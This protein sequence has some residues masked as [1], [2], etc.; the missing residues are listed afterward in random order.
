VEAV[1]QFGFSQ[2][3]LWMIYL[4]ADR[5]VNATQG[6]RDVTPPWMTWAALALVVVLAGVAGAILHKLL[7]RNEAHTKKGEVVP[8]ELAMLRGVIADLPDTFFVKDTESRFLLANLA[9][10]KN[11]GANSVAEMLGKT[12]F[13]FFPKE[14]A[15]TFFEN[16]R[17]VLDG[18][19]AH[20]SKEERI[21][22]AD[23]KTR[24]LLTTKVPLTDH[25]GKTAGLVGIG[26]D[27][28]ELKAVEAQL[29]R[30][31]D[32]LAFKA[33]H[34]SLTGLM[35]RAAILEQLEHELA[36]CTR[37]KGSLAVLLADLD[38]FKKINDGYGHPAG[39]EVLR[40]TAHRLL[41]SVRIYDLV[42][43]Y[44]GEEFLIV[45]PSCS[46]TA[47]AMARAEQMRSDLAAAPVW[48]EHGPITATMSMGVLVTDER[49]FAAAAAMHD[50]DLA[51]Y[52][53]KESGRNRCTLVAAAVAGVR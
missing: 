32:E 8:G 9:A 50:V 4:P 45:L 47:V 27:V 26:R 43:R 39:D 28:T 23:G 1:N 46:S 49:H 12:D 38:H 6:V 21:K 52:E 42:G 2:L 3:G 44:G 25:A 53:A 5:L 36:R 15:E 33:A 17:R 41:N 22:D 30:A 40:E 7:A 31:R 34:D 29:E 24:V 35:N 19:M 11:V 13:D 37:E 51:L 16:E 10:A 48:T 18:S 20:V 14:I